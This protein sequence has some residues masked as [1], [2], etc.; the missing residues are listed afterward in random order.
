MNSN[1]QSGGLINL[2]RLLLP[3]AVI[4]VLGSLGFGW[5]VKSFLVISALLA[6]LP[7]LGIAG[8]RWWL[9][10]SL[11]QAPCPVCGYELAA[12][13]NNPQI[14]CPSC[15]ETLQASDGK[16]IRATPPGTIDVTAIELDS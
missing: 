14:S 12:L 6:V 7:I 13:K 9:N 3:I 8:F 4:W 1:P 10:R 16:F 5:L 2:S 11:V 15:N